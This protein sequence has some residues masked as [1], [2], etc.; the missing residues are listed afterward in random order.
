MIERDVRKRARL[1]GDALEA[2]AAFVERFKGIPCLVCGVELG[3]V[4][5]FGLSVNVRDGVV[6]AVAA[7]H[8]SC[9]ARSIGMS[10]EE[11]QA[12]FAAEMA[13]SSVGVP[14]RGRRGRS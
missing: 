2:G 9:T 11:G 1:D 12:R 14:S 7:M 5:E 13:V 6:Y 4:G 8:L 3:D 10:V